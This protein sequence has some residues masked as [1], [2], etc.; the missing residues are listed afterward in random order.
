[1]CNDDTGNV[2]HVILHIFCIP[3][4]LE[5]AEMMRFLCCSG[6]LVLG[7][8]VYSASNRNEYKKHKNNNVSGE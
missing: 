1:V 2:I 8:G 4:F 3:E 7:P 6:Y 5:S